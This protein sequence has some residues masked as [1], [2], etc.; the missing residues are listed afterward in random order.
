M[1]KHSAHQPTSKTRR[2]LTAIAVAPVAV[3]ALTSVILGLGNSAKADDTG[4]PKHLKPRPVPD[5]SLP[6]KLPRADLARLGSKYTVHE[7]DTVKDLA[8][9]FG[10]STAELLAAN[11]L[12]WRTMLAVGQELRVPT[13]SAGTSAPVVSSEIRSH[14]VVAGDTLE[15]IARSHHVQPRAIMSANGLHKTSRLV[16]GQR[17]VIPNAELMGTLPAL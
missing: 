4:A 13:E 10:V 11:G 7:G 17:L 12:S 3:A 2:R 15:A 8:A 6:Q 1:S 14:R 9:Q 16:V 5:A